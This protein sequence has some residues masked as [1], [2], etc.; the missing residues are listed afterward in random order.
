MPSIML[1]ATGKLKII[2]KT[3]W[4]GVTMQSVIEIWILL[5][6]KAA[7]LMIKLLKQTWTDFP[8]KAG[9]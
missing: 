5:R 6:A 2:K 9:P 7:S 3:P 8:G 1:I 4:K